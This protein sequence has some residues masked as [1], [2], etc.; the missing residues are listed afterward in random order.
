MIEAELS[1][2]NVQPPFS[3]LMSIYAGNNSSDLNEALLSI[4]QQTLSPSEVVLV[5]DG[6]ISASLSSIVQKYRL[7]LNIV[8]VKL[9]KNMGHGYALNFG[10]K[11]CSNDIVARM[12]GDDI[13]L[14]RRFQLQVE[15]LMSHPNVSVSSG[16][17][18]EF[19]NTTN[20]IVGSRSL[21]CGHKEIVRFAKYRSPVSHP[22]VI[23]R[24]ADVLSVGGY[25]EVH[26]EDYPLWCL[27]LS[28]GF[29]FSNINET[30]LLMRVGDSFQSRRGWRFYLSEINMVKYQY[31]IGFISLLE[32]II[33]LTL[34]LFLRSSPK[35]I[36]S[37]IYKNR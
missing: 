19:V 35:A 28:K 23:F 27:M 5:E 18:D 4:S 2:I 15:H 8:S 36:R 29:L 20:N 31:K 16:R 14:P 25:P 21:P 6:F 34:R 9:E 13:C 1:S 12:D 26:P 10:L 33:S 24:K 11:K 30:I 32:L 3:V 37:L 17:I 7:A 22:A